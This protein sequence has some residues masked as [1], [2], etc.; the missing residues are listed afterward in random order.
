MI[1]LWLAVPESLMAIHTT[2]TPPPI[3][4]NT[5]RTSNHTF[6]SCFGHREHRSL[7]KRLKLLKHVWHN[8]DPFLKP[9]YVFAMPEGMDHKSIQQF[10][11]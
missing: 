2:T 6:C 9:K 5:A 1:S 8:L 11:M 7:P 10:N 4:E 3:S